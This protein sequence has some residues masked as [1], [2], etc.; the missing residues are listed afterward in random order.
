M[1]LLYKEDPIS[2]LKEGKLTEKK[3]QKMLKRL[4]PEEL[5]AASRFLMEIN[6]QHHHIP[7]SAETKKLIIE[8]LSDDM[9]IDMAVKT[10][11]NDYIC[12][13]AIGEMK[14][15]G[16]LQKVLQFYHRVSP[17]RIFMW[18][19]EKL[20]YTERPI[21]NGY[22]RGGLAVWSL[23]QRIDQEHFKAAWYNCGQK[24]K[25]VDQL[26]EK[27]GEGRYFSGY[28]LP[29]WGERMTMSYM[30]LLP[31]AEHRII[32]AESGV[33]MSRPYHTYVDD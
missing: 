8:Q 19:D 6:E 17:F 23:M 12:A 7:V 1:T 16:S 15:Q 2:L 30:D 5:A 9:L 27:K 25:W 20:V 3:L 32:L 18:Q 28:G 21:G 4:S 29:G 11:G 33:E 14:D 10:R 24:S 31:E 26:R 22:E 13:L